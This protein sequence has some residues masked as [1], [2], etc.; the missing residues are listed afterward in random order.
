MA[1]VHLT[2]TCSH[3]SIP[4]FKGKPREKARVLVQPD[5]SHEALHVPSEGRFLVF[6]VGGELSQRRPKSD[7]GAGGGRRGAEG[8]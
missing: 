8:E 5:G 4:L 1:L 6:R 7:G 3:V 2:V